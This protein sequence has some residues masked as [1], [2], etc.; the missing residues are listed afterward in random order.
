VELG[1]RGGLGH[2]DGG[3]DAQPRGRFGDAE[4]VVAGRGGDN[5]AG[6]GGVVEGEQAVQR[7][8]QLETARLLPALALEPDVATGPRCQR[9][10]ALDRRAA[11]VAAQP[12]GGL[13]D[14]ARRDRVCCLHPF[15]SSHP[16]ANV[17]ATRSDLLLADGINVFR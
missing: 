15:D 11:H 4:G 2:D 9:G 13:F 8:T 3:A 12:L 7:A 16:R 17:D 1:G 5:A 6:A 10:R 14:V